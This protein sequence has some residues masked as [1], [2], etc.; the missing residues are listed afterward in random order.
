MRTT[1]S[2]GQLDDSSF[3]GAASAWNYRGAILWLVLNLVDLAESLVAR[4][5]G[6]G[7]LNPFIPLNSPILALCYKGLLA[8]G[9]LVFLDRIKRPQLIEWLNIGMILVIAWN[10]LAILVS[11]S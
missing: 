4:E 7:E 11:K 9:V 1:I 10:A 2:K 8:V 6:C 3:K 5:I